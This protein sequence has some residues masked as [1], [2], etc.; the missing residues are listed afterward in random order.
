MTCNHQRGKGSDTKR[1]TPHNLGYPISVLTSA[2][3]DAAKR[4]DVLGGDLEEVPVH[5]VPHVSPAVRLDALDVTIPAGG[6][7][8]GLH[9]SVDLLLFFLG[10]DIKRGRKGKGWGKGKVGTCGG[11]EDEG[12]EGGREGDARETEV[13][14][15]FL[16]RFG[17]GLFFWTPPVAIDRSSPRSVPKS[18]RREEYLL[19]MLV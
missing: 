8:P 5:I 10:K 19:Y 16:L 13:E 2:T 14:E 4:G 1:R 17:D 18:Q 9:H 12:K 3:A 7:G 15:H 11:E 6:G